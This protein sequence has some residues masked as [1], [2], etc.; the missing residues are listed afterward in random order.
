[1][2]AFTSW[3]KI[4]LVIEV[5]NCHHYR[6]DP[7]SAMRLM[8]EA[9]NLHQKCE[10]T[11]CGYFMKKVIMWICQSTDRWAMTTMLIM[12]LQHQADGKDPTPGM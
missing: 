2:T 8:M 4:W 1:M 5:A 10:L 3:Q 6:R 11:V 9:L 7:W 12:N